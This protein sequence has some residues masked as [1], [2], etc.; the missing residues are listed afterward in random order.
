MHTEAGSLIFADAPPR[1]RA[2]VAAALY[3][4]TIVT[5]IIAQGFIAERM[6]VSTSAA[7]TAANIVADPS[8]Y[9]AGFTIFMVEMVAQIGMVGLFY[10]LLK[11]VSP[12]MA[13]IAAAIGF[14]GCG[15]KALARLFYYAPLLLLGNPPDQSVFDAP[16]LHE[17]A[18][19]FI[20]IN[21][22]AA[23]IALIF[24]GFESL[25]EGWLM[26]RSTYFPRWLGVLSMIGGAGW[27]TFL[28]P[29]LGSRAFMGVALFALIGSLAT[30][31][32]MFIFGVREAQW[33]A[34]VGAR[35]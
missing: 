6:I 14:T 13:L 1:T 3:L 9:R 29:P 12:S 23:A 30:I 4:T 34:V 21:D 33:R 10:G 8:L 35:S 22:Q 19:T 26:V 7:T 20:R 27:L 18:L 17:L 11:P 15:I 24:F 25:L 5:G 32:W 31:V 28:W 2:R 16:Q